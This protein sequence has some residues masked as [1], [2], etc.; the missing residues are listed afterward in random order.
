MQHAEVMRNDSSELLMS[1]AAIKAC[2]QLQENSDIPL[3]TLSFWRHEQQQ[4]CGEFD[5]TELAGE[6]RQVFEK[7]LGPHKPSLPL[8]PMTKRQRLRYNQLALS[9]RRKRRAA[10]LAESAKRI[11]TKIKSKHSKFKSKCRKR[12][13]RGEE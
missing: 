8:I 11:A 1:D 10:F 3:H 6:D 4:C 13:L 7:F 12:Y 2:K 9:E 5:V